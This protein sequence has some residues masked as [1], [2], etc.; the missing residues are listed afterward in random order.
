[1][2]NI[3]SPIIMPFLN[4][5]DKYNISYLWVLLMFSIIIFGIEYLVTKKLALNRK[6]IVLTMLLASIMS[7]IM[8]VRNG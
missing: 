7:Q 4:F 6:I 1:M 5:C 8:I 3:L 2:G